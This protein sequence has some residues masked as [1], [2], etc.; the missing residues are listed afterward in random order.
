MHVPTTTPQ[1]EADVPAL[2][3]LTP[4]IGSRFSGTSHLDHFCDPGT[5]GYRPPS[6][7][8]LIEQARQALIDAQYARNPGERYAQAHLAALRAAAAVLA[9]RARPRRRAA[10]KSAWTLVS[11]VAPEL[12]EW[13]AFFAAAS[14][15]RAA[16]EAGIPR[17]V[18]DRDADDMV[19]QAGQFLTI[20]WRSATKAVR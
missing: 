20:A 17:L 14:A 13:A 16:V 11:T 3:S 18:T 8:L 15:T 1:Q 6:A 2:A 7:R 9:V 12:S 19:R 10:P 5:T 4:P